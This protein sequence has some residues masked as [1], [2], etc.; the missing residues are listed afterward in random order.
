[1]SVSHQSQSQRG[2]YHAPGHLSN[3]ERCATVAST[4]GDTTPPPR[5]F[6]SY[7]FRTDVPPMTEPFD[8]AQQILDFEPGAATPYHTH[9]GIV[10]VTVVIGEMTFNLDGVDKI[11]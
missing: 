11:Y 2:Q 8:V 7:Q 1:M 5:N 9:S 4:T 10:M 3:P 6:V